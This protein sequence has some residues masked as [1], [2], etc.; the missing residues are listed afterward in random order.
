MY[1]LMHTREYELQAIHIFLY[2]CA[3]CLYTADKNDGALQVEK[4][5]ETT[6]M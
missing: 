5:V 6:S 3:K 1:V 2:V 4:G